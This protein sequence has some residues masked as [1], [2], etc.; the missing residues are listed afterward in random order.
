MSVSYFTQELCNCVIS[1]MATSGH[2]GFCPLVEFAH[3]FGRGIGAHFFSKYPKVPKS[4]LKRT[5]ALHGHGSPGYD[6][7]IIG[8][9]TYL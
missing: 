2:F 1:K 6:P 7:T 5:F 3:T 9:L 8:E 4:I